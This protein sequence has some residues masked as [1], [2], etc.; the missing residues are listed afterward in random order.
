MSLRLSSRTSALTPFLAMEVME[1]GLSLARQGRRVVQLGVGEPDFDAPPEV[2][3]ATIAALEGGRTHYTDSRGLLPLREAIAAH[4]LARRGVDLSPERVL[5]TA[6]T[7]PAMLLV[8]TALL[9]PGDEVIIPTPHYPCYPTIVR[10]AGGTPV[11]VP[12]SPD[13]DYRIDPDAV[14][15]ALSPRTRAIL[16]GSPANPT[17]AVQPPDVIE[18]LLALGPP[19]VS[20]EIYDGLLYDDARVCS[21]LGLAED[22]FILDGFSKR[23]AMTGFRLGW[24]IAPEAAVRGLQTLQQNLFISTNHFVQE[25][26]IAALAHGAP[27]AA[28]M[29]VEYARRRDLL[30]SGLEALGL[31]VP[32][33]PRGA[34]YAFADAR[35]FGQ[36]SLALAFHLLDETGVAAGPGRDFGALGEGFLRFSFCA[37]PE[38]IAEGLERLAP[39]LSRLAARPLRG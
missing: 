19:L 11:L 14:R 25:A 37:A 5:V 23:Y 35:R 28:R 8:F 16:V 6:G 21:P 32:A 30:I 20:D 1:R 34:F 33:P 17:G 18:A 2:V 10:A 29:C 24:V 39:A 36:D 22:A 27:T 38:A 9:D 4:Y 3:R 7:S 13:D 15:R 31:H 26:G 12:T